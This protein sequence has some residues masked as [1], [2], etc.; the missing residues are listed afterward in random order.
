MPKTKIILASILATSLS[1][2]CVQ[3]DIVGNIKDGINDNI[4]GVLS[5]N[6]L[7]LD[8]SKIL[9]IP[10]NSTILGDSAGPLKY[11]C[12]LGDLGGNFNFGLGNIDLGNIFKSIN[13]GIIKCDIAID[14]DKAVCKDV[15]YNSAKDKIYDIY[16][17]EKENGAKMGEQGREWLKDK[18]FGFMGDESATWG[19][20][21]QEKLN[22]YCSDIDDGIWKSKQDKNGKGEKSVA[23]KNVDRAKNTSGLRM[24]ANSMFGINETGHKELALKSPE[25]AK[26]VDSIVKD[27]TSSDG[28]IK[29]PTNEQI[30]TAKAEFKKI[31]DKKTTGGLSIK[32]IENHKTK[33]QE[34]IT[35]NSFLNEAQKNSVVNQLE[36]LDRGF[37]EKAREACFDIY[38]DDAYKLENCVAMKKTDLERECYEK[39]ECKKIFT[40][41]QEQRENAQAVVMDNKIKANATKKPTY[42]IEEI[43]AMPLSDND[44]SAMIAELEQAIAKEN[45]ETAKTTMNLQLMNEL[46]RL[47]IKHADV[48]SKSFDATT[49]LQAT[50]AIIKASQE[51]AQKTVDGIIGKG[52][53][54]GIGGGSFP[55]SPF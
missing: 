12:S 29:K 16:N 38:K 2:S 52:G 4:S 15:F 55:S 27:L 45:L 14:A 10:T 9:G 39:G 31:V 54:S 7:N 3:A 49:S 40:N 48:I 30:Q 5:G 19:K 17:T 23:E 50:Q 28:Q 32:N 20:T 35:Q 22:K 37:Q 44:R 34:I 24:L 8:I 51:Q 13:F 1:V 18:L 43:N 46:S 33:S 53:S 6:G 25:F 47:E 42:T 21:T 36:Q 11:S 26:A 41:V